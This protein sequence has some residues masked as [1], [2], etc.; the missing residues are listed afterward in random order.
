MKL[1]VAYA[2][3]RA[4]KSQSLCALGCCHVEFGNRHTLPTSPAINS[5]GFSVEELAVFLTTLH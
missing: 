1:K 5:R 2:I 4:I 3:N